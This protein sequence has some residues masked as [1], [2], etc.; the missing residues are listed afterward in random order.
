MKVDVSKLRQLIREAEAS[1]HTHVQHILQEDGPLRPG[2][3]VKVVR[4]CGKP[5]CHCATGQGHPSTYLSSKQD[6]RTR[7]VYVSADDEAS[8]GQEALRYRQLRRRRAALAKLSRRAL[9]LI[10]EFEAAL[11]VSEAV[12]PVN[13]EEGKGRKAEKKTDHQGV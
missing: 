8:V 11:R 3:L 13:N 2:S 1:R 6:G 5:T 10:D 9:E 12:V 7:M 4:K